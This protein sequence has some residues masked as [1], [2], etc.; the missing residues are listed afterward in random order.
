MSLRLSGF[1]MAL[2]I[3]CGQ[4]AQQAREA[5]REGAAWEAQALREALTRMNEAREILERARPTRVPP[6][7]EVRPG[8][9]PF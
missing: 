4:A 5:E 9:R 7:E 8:E 6:M 1:K 3:Q 2:V